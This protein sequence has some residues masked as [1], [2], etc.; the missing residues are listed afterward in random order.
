MK[1]LIS[2]L[3]ILVISFQMTAQNKKGITNN[4][5]S[6]ALDNAVIYEA[7]IRQYSQEGTFNAFTKD[8]PKLKKLGVK[9]IWL[10][11]IHEV[12]MKNRKA[13][14]NV[15][16]E[17][18]PENEK[19]KY[20][21]SHYSVKDYRSVT[22]NYGTQKDFDKLVQ[23]A[24]KNGMYVILDW[25]ANHTAWD[26]AWMTN[27]P[28]YYTKGKDGKFVSPFDWTDVADLN[29]DNPEMRKA[30]L[31]DMK[32]WITDHNIDGFRCDVAMEVPRDFWDNTSAEL[33]KV[34]PVFMLMEAEQPDLMQ[35]AFDMQYG[36]TVHH[37][38]NKIYK[39]EN[40]VKD[41]DA[42]IEKVSTSNEADD[43]Y[44]NFTSN[45][46]ENSWNGTEY[47]RLNDAVETF[48]AL[49]FIMPG[50]PL[51]YNGQEYDLNRRLKF[52]EKDQFP[53]TVGKMM[54][55]YQ[56]LGKL[57]SENPALNGGKSAAAYKRIQTSAD[58]KVLAFQREAKGKK[59]IYL[60]NLSKT[61]QEFTV[62]FDGKYLDYMSGKEV[63][64]TK[65]QKLGFKPWEYKILTV[66]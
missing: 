29:Y 30:M 22:P 20:F 23:T 46:D 40:T 55:V 49:T 17:Q 35:D 18:I 37:I 47:E 48:A 9:I 25:V 63:I 14:G 61:A 53:H 8:I 16:I 43:I 50:M 66:K 45:H 1:K 54:A 7:N 4:Y 5:K 62:G 57:K 41:F 34:K 15:S 11:P 3:G 64:L 26:H 44:M 12:G 42:Y 52:F 56:K 24:H 31:E 33:N 38:F 59:V 28:E 58:D 6:S 10:M 51:V 2:I 36:W 27:H 39:G 60:G 32:Y 19:A 21:G 13:Y 65:G